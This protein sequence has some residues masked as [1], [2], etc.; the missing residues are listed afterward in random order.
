VSPSASPLPWPKAPGS[1]HPGA[2]RPAGPPPAAD[3]APTSAPYI[4]RLLPG[5]GT[6]QVRN[7]FTGE[8]T[9]TIAPPAGQFFAGITAAGDDRTFVLQA[10][11]G[12]SM[13]NGPIPVNP[14]SAAFD[15]MRLRPDGRLE[16]LSVLGTVPAG[17]ALSGFAVSQDASML[18][19][20]TGAGFETVSLATG[21]GKHWLPVDHGTAAPLGLSWAGDR[22]LAFGWGRGNNPNP[23]GMGIRL[24]DVAAPG[25]LLQASRLVVPPG[26]YC[27]GRGVCRGN[28]VITADGSK[29]LVTRAIQDGSRYTSS[30]AEYSARTGQLLATPAPPVTSGFP[31]KVCVA[32]WSSP[33]GGRVVS[34]CG[35][36]ERYDHGRVSTI[37]IHPPRYGTNL[38][39]FAWVGALAADNSVA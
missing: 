38:L 2:W 30:V 9:A 17:T 10:E 3:V 26:R 37:T 36:Y 15:E 28:P 27:V 20:Y 12:G 32:L 23:P 16:S 8:T 5:L 34:F 14:T 13:A 11:V 4:V 35:P 7:V 19:Y 33:S 18:V 29:V 31:G 21:T 39:A 24:L 6:A 25:N 1:W 22:T